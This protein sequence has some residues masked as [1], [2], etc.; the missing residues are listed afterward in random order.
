MEPTQILLFVV[1]ITLTI[2]LTLI[3]VQLYFLLKDL[4]KSLKKVD[5]ILTEGTHLTD[6]IARSLTAVS[7]VLAGIKSSL[8]VLNFLNKK[9][10]DKD[11]KER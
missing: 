9:E 5:L 8:S 6:K 1:I 10:K 7:A 4:R 11:G 2:I 3:G